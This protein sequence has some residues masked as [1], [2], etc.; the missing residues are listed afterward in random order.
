MPVL[1]IRSTSRPYISWPKD[2]EGFPVKDLV[3][4]VLPAAVAD[5]C[6]LLNKAIPSSAAA[7]KSIRS[8]LLTCRDDHF[9][10]WEL[11]GLMCRN[12]SRVRVRFQPS[13][14]RVG[15]RIFAAHLFNVELKP[16]EPVVHHRQFRSH[17]LLELN[18][19]SATLTVTRLKASAICCIDNS[20]PASENVLFFHLPG[21]SNAS[22]AN[23]PTHTICKFVVGLSGC[24]SCPRRIDSPNPA[25]SFESG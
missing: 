18:H 15:Q 1:S 9:E 12:G 3:D 23:A 22:T 7:A 10:P 13:I 25:I 24:W 19:T 20:S 21:S 6:V 17:I 11:F 8:V 5:C 16:F 4:R 14:E 2:A